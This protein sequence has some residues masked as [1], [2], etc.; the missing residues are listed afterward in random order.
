MDQPWFV[1]ILSNYTRNVFYF[2]TTNDLFHRLQSH[3][4]GKGSNFAPEYNLKYLIYREELPNKHHALTRE[5]QLKNWHRDSKI[6][7]I[8]KK[9]PTVR[10]LSAEAPGPMSPRIDPD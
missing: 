2:G 10:D 9:N 5:K 7:L 6:A 3:H 8:Q 4:E 1:Y